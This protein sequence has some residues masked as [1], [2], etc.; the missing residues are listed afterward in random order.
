MK[1][2]IITIC[3]VVW[4]LFIFYL[5]SIPPNKL[6]NINIIEVDKLVH[7]F[8]YGGLGFWLTL[9]LGLRGF[10]GLKLVAVV[11]FISIIYA[12]IDEWHQPF[13]GRTF[14]LYDILAD[15][16]GLATTTIPLAIFFTF[17]KEKEAISGN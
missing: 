5:T 15:V 13:V 12:F 9:F 10:R 2:K 16:I 14:S 3:L 4:W 1:S 11:I 7:L 8:M 17:R 6:P